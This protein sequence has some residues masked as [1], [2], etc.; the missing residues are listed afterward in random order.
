[1]KK[2]FIDCGFHHGEGLKQFLLGLGIDNHWQVYV[3][4]PNPACKLTTR[5]IQIFTDTQI[6]VSI[7]EMAVWIKDGA[8]LFNQ[9]NHFKTGSGS[10]TDGKSM[11]DGW[12]SSIADLNIQSVIHQ[13]PIAVPC[14][15]FS[16][17]I[18]ST[19]AD[20]VALHND[21]EIYVKMDI[22]GAE[23]AVLRKMLQDNTV[24]FIHKIWIEFHERFV[25]GES[26]QTKADLIKEI[27]KH[28][29]VHEWD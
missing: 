6:P 19:W 1:M 5:A 26:V 20:A 2:I 23:F 29:M 24:R 9:E 11:L 13:D 10:P 4:E 17:F 7:Q 21:V 18:R 15:D 25:P 14:I 3:F 27:S 16:A 12:Q 22:E 28:T 8:V